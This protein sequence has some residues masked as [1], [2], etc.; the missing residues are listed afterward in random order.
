MLLERYRP[1]DGA[2]LI[3]GHT[4]VWIRLSIRMSTKQ[5]ETDRSLCVGTAGPFGDKIRQGTRLGK[6]MGVHCDE[7]PLRSPCRTSLKAAWR[8]SLSSTH[9]RWQ[10]AAVMLNS[11]PHGER[12]GLGLVGEPS[13][14]AEVTSR[15]GHTTLGLRAQTLAPRGCIPPFA[16]PFP[17]GP[18]QCPG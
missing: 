15:L 7:L 18:A 9:A 13:C 6:V 1:R 5:R 17:P 4:S 2:G 16:N 12:T 11:K 8:A 10:H 14:G 3:N